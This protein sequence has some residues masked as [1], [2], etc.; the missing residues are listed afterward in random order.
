VRL[1]S[2]VSSVTA[3]R[4]LDYLSTAGYHRTKLRTNTSLS[5]SYSYPRAVKMLSSGAIDVK[6]LITHSYP[7]KNA[8]DAFEHVKS[9]RDGAIKVVILG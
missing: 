6:P 5:D 3:T 7:L 8:V 4:K 9:G 2:R 1:I